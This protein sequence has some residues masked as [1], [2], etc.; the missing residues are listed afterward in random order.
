MSHRALLQTLTHLRQ[1]RITLA[2]LS[3]PALDELITRSQLAEYL[4]TTVGRLAQ[5]SYHG[6]GI[7]FVKHGRK[8]LYRRSDVQ[9]Y[10]Q[11]NTFQST[12][13]A[14]GVV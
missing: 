11:D 7:P 5:D 2:T 10:L 13:D 8:V 9:K 14:Q 6:R 12:A 3:S 1:G 4:H